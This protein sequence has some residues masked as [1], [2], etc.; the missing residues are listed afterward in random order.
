MRNIFDTVLSEM[1]RLTDLGN[2]VHGHFV[3]L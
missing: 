2:T 3:F 1:F